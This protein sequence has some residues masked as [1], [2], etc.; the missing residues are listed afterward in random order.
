MGWDGWTEYQK[1]PSNFF[2]LCEYIENVYTYLEVFNIKPA[3]YRL[4]YI[5]FW[6]NSPQKYTKISIKKIYKIPQKYCKNSTK[7]QP[8][9]DP[10]N[11]N[12]ISTGPI[13]APFFN[14]FDNFN[15]LFVIISLYFLVIFEFRYIW[16]SFWPSHL[17]LQR[18]FLTNHEIRL[19]F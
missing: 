1:C 13:L 9:H 2:I 16:R 4:K 10:W 5:H 14:F 3:R 19:A 17:I 7:K 6:W 12:L 15:V 11:K 18:I 8:K